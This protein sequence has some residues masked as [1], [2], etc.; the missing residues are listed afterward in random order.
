MRLEN[1]RD[2]FKGKEVSDHLD[3]KP[4]GL[5][6]KTLRNIRNMLSEALDFAVNNLR[7]L[8]PNPIQGL[9]TPKVT[10]ARLKSSNIRYAIEE[11]SLEHEN[12]NALMVLIDLY[13]GLRIGE[14]CGLVWSDSASN[15]DFFEVNRLVER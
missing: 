4:G 2:F 8:E 12:I 14:L 6:P 7:W 3:G 13:T 11:T 5:S 15:K 9:K 10:I 1:L